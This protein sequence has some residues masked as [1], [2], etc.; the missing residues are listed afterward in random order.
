MFSQ[1]FLALGSFGQA[2]PFLSKKGFKRY[3]ALP[4]IINLG[5]L[6]LAV[7][8]SIE[9]GSSFTDYFLNLIGLESGSWAKY[10]GWLVSFIIRFIILMVYFSLFRYILLILLSPFLSFLSEKVDKYE[11]GGD[12]PFSFK[13]LGNDIVRS[14]RINLRNLF[15]E[16]LLTL[17]FG[18]MTFIPLI[19]LLSP[20]AILAV[21][22]YFFG[23][24]MMDYNAERYKWDRKST[25]KWMKK[26]Y[27]SVAGI[28]LAFHLC[29][30]I[31]VLGWIVAPVLATIAGTLTFL[32]L[33]PVEKR[34][35]V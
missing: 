33:N 32:R 2:F 13:Q 27:A 8:V 20:F 10:A 16:L 17:V 11:N 6:I 19:G 18:L 4:I 21:Q 14:I 1:F 28:G 34:S 31:P 26:N 15:L 35:N 30:L 29:F 5:L 9:Y 3:L 7:W 23:F 24:A 22:S 25:A 12:F